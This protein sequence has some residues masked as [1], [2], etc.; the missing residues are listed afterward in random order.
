MSKTPVAMR[1][2]GRSC[3]P[4][5]HPG[6]YLFRRVPDWIWDDPTDRPGPEAIELPDM[7]VG[8]SRYGH[9]EWVRYDVINNR[10]YEK[11]G[12]LG[13]Q[14]QD[15]PPK[16]WDLGVYKY[17]FQSCH[18]PLEN[19]YPHTEIRVSNNG[20]R[21]EL[22]K[23]LPEDIHLKWRLALLD[24]VEAIIKPMQIVPLRET[25]PV[26]HKLEPHSVIA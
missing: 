24:V 21:I 23:D 20:V 14:V 7:S 11:W 19:D 3:D 17:T 13:V 1:T 5:F 12:V 16:Y 8:R 15:I 22:L 18:D 2:N 26:S 9:A 6:E 10:H 25:A 4:H